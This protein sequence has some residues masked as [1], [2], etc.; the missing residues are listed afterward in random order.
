MVDAWSPP[1]ALI[2]A[3]LLTALYC[4]TFGQ[5]FT[6]AYDSGDDPTMALIAAG[7]HGTPGQITIV[8]P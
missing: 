2:A 6:P 3:T 4:I 5:V 1:R 7:L 8:E